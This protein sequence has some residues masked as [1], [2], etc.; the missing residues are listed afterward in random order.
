M[1]RVSNI[2]SITV[3]LWVLETWRRELFA[4]FF[5]IQFVAIRA[6]RSPRIALL[7]S[8]SVHAVR[9]RRPLFA[10]WRR[11]TIRNREKGT[12]LEIHRAEQFYGCVKSVKNCLC[13]KDRRDFLALRCYAVASHTV[14]CALSLTIREDAR[15]APR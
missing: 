4:E 9:R 3:T 7:Q 1:L 14:C 13:G 12:L 11:K 6:R 15:S 8:L 5:A 10:R 2:S